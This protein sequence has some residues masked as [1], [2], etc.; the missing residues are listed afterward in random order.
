MIG[1]CFDLL[2]IL[3]EAITQNRDDS[4]VSYI[5]MQCLLIKK[6]V[7]RNISVFSYFMKFCRQFPVRHYFQENHEYPFQLWICASVIFEVHL[8]H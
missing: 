1:P 5:F 8:I 7:N 6:Y 4:N 2:P 3:Q